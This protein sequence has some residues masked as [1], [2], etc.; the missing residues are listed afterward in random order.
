MTSE[1][2]SWAIQTAFDGGIQQQPEVAAK[3]SVLD[4][5]NV[6]T[7]FS[8]AERR[9]GYSAFPGLRSQNSLTTAIGSIYNASGTL[10]YT[11]NLVGFTFPATPAG[12]TFVVSVPVSTFVTSLGGLA[13][14]ANT[15]PPP[16]S[17]S[18]MGVQTTTRGVV[19]VDAPPTLTIPDAFITWANAFVLPSDYAVDVSGNVNLVF[20]LTAPISGVSLTA[21]FF[22]TPLN[23]PT[24]SL[25]Q[26][27]QFNGGTGFLQF[28][29]TTANISTPVAVFRLSDTI[30]T[31]FHFKFAAFL[32]GFPQ[33]S[34]FPPQV[35]VIP[36][37]DLAYLV[38]GGGTVKIGR[39][40]IV[41]GTNTTTNTA[42]ATTQDGTVVGVPPT[43]M[44]C[45]GT[46]PGGS[47]IINFRQ[48]LFANGSEQ[49]NQ[50]NILFWNY[51][52]L[53][54]TST[55][56]IVDTTNIWPVTAFSALS[57]ARDNSEITALFPVGDNLGVSKKNSIWLAVLARA[58]TP[59]AIS[60]GIVTQNAVLVDQFSVQLVVPGVGFLAPGSVQAIPG[61]IF[62]LSEDAFY[63]FDGTP[64][65]KPKS[66]L[67]AD[68]IDR[69]NPG[70]KSFAQGVNWRT[71]RM[72]FCA[73]S[74][75]DNSTT[76]DTVIVYDYQSEAWW[77]LQGRNKSLD[78]VSWTVID[79]VGFKEELW[80]QDSVGNL[81]KFI[82]DT[83]YGIP[84]DSYIV[85][86]RFNE[87][88]IL[89]ADVTEVRTQ[90]INNQQTIVQ[91]SVQLLIDDIPVATQDA[92]QPGA[93][94][95]PINFPL[96]GE[97]LWSAPPVSGVSTYAPTR[98]RQRKTPITG[99]GDWFQ[100]KV[101]NCMQYLMVAFGYTPNGRR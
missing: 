33:S 4:A 85:T 20:F 40:D 31:S 16:F 60:G 88:A 101:M 8:R 1:K 45:Y 68:Y 27:L 30:A 99:S 95:K 34:A 62:G 53:S 49:N 56:A 25:F 52:N 46:F 82:G 29:T 15:S 74:L 77:V 89:E 61:G 98:R 55:G 22:F 50:Q 24:T 39:K 38:F 21:A 23:L 41:S 96:S 42:F 73:V 65:I 93:T 70:R 67:I 59:G 90:S 79:G 51:G 10:V 19:I 94:T 76:N 3:N 35:T 6:W 86:Q 13:F 32:F 54:E 63:L 57:D 5:L 18:V 100:A 12:S 44:A 2:A 87:F 91:P 72:Y 84:I 11:H 37:L 9:P 78:I 80:F 58:A 92:A 83:D 66:Y 43:A 71:Q 26:R 14:L 69:I 64:N 36:E 7:P 47:Q 28:L 81:N 97:V 48:H 17:L 75:D